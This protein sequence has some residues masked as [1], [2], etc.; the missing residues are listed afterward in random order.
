M[1][2]AQKNQSLVDI[3]N[4]VIAHADTRF[5]MEY[6]THCHFCCGCCRCKRP[7]R[8]E[9]STLPVVLEDINKS[10]AV[11]VL[12]L[13]ETLV[14]CSFHPTDYYD[15]CIS[16]II[17][18]ISYDV[19][20]QKRPFVDQ[21]LSECFKHFFVVI[22]TASL[23]Q[24]ANPIIDVICPNLP[25]SQRLF[26]ESCTFCEGL[27]VKDLTIF[28]VPLDRVIIV[29]NNPCSFLMHPANAILSITWEG[30]REDWELRDY[31]LPLLM[32]CENAPDVRK[33]L[34]SNRKEP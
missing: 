30:D 19:Y 1:N 14:H 12:D 3:E 18:E 11:L 29:D 27:F 34:A 16:I 9:H 24:Y 8:N 32:K 21:F 17:D 22:F 28:K 33:V 20:I 26:R 2:D 7:R 13:D 31:I 15:F 10:E 4:R 25:A 6:E 5:E 23:P